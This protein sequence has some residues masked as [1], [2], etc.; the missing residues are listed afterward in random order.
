[1]VEYFWEKVGMLVAILV[2]SVVCGFLPLAFKNV[3]PALKK[4]LLSYGN[5]FAGGVFFAIG[6]V[7]CYVYVY[8]ES[9]FLR[10]FI[11]HIYIYTLHFYLFL[12][13]I[14]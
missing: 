8:Y 4:R 1:M 14:N 6:Y 2:S 3:R 9:I 11:Q 13:L 5:C 12:T 7:I 10:V